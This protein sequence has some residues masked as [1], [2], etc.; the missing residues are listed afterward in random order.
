MISD[1]SIEEVRA[2]CEARGS[3][4]HCFVVSV[5]DANGDIVGDVDVEVEEHPA[6]NIVVVPP[7]EERVRAIIRARVER[8][9]LG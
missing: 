3:R 2:I 8:V 6:E 1:E 9:S 7:F 4:L 5:I